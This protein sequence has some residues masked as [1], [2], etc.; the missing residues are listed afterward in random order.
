[1][2]RLLDLFNNKKKRKYLNYFDSFLLLIMS[3]MFNNFNTANK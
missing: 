3:A 1:M 2:N